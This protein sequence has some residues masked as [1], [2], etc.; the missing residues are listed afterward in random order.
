MD[1]AI[2]ETNELHGYILGHKLGNMYYNEN[3]YH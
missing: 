1:E 3:V 2:N